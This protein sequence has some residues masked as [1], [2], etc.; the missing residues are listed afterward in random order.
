MDIAGKVVV[1]T[2]GA[3]G[4]GLSTA[5]MFVDAGAKVAIMDVKED[6][7]ETAKA[8]LGGEVL[9]VVTNVA[10]EDSVVAAYDK[11]VEHFGGVDVAVLNAGILRDGLLVKAD[12]E[13][14]KVVRKMSKEQWQTVI[15]VNLT[16][17]FLTGR[18]AAARM[19][20]G[21]RKGVMVLMSSIARH[22][23]MGQSNY[24]AAKAGVYALSVVWGRELSRFGIR[25]ASVSPGLI[26]TPMVLRDMRQEMLEKIKKR[27][28]VGRLGDPAEIAHAVQ[29]IV[30]NDLI[31][32]QNIEPSGGMVL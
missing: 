31:T 24:S 19:I 7:I 27:I 6:A 15:D 2:G 23:N 32:A 28:P 4:I 14:G 17:V 30:E 20:D 25:V 8:E 21:G 16:G 9:G 11:V 3:Q 5:K 26:G 13:T 29:F 1:V 12:R 10:D 22:G 18:E